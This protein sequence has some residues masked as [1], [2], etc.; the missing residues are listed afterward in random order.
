MLDQKEYYEDLAHLQNHPDVIVIDIMTITGFMDDS[1][2]VDHLLRYA[3]YT[4]DMEL[5]EKYS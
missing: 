2:K 4:N 3:K 1:A 5:V